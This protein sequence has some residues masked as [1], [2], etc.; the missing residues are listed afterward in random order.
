[1]DADS[2]PLV[3]VESGPPQTAIR[4][5]ESKRS[6]QVQMGAG[7]RAKADDIACIWWN[8]RLEEHNVEQGWLVRHAEF[9]H[10]PG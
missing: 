5:F 1:M 8:F 9:L 6:D 4:P 7:I 10:F 2:G 3:I